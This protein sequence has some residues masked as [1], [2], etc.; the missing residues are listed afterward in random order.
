M[1]KRDQ[2]AGILGRTRLQ[3][4]DNQELEDY[5]EEKYGRGG[6]EEGCVRF[7]VNISALYHAERHRAALRFLHPQSHETILDAGCGTGDLA[8]QIAPHCRTIHAID[9]AGNALNPAHRAIANLQ[10]AKMN[11][12]TLAFADGS[13]D[14]IVCVETLEHLLAPDRALAE[15]SRILKP[16]GRLI[17]T[18][19]TVNRT[20]VQ[21]IQTALRLTRPLEISEHLNE[22]SYTEVVRHAGAAG[23]ALEG[24][25][26]IVFDF[27]VLGGL[28]LISKFAT[29]K[30]TALSLKIHAFPRNSAFIAAAFRKRG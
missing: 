27:G 19:P 26:G 14:Q 9:I 20:I 24:S 25:E 10:F 8:A 7:G 17:L 28:K 1:M 30:M 16:A 6:Y 13:F 29:E 11:A 4:R 18:Y 5:Y 15:F 21:T 12:E 2:S 22:W 3:F 23:F